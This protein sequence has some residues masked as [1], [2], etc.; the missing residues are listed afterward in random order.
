MGVALEKHFGR[1]EYG[2]RGNQDYPL[3]RRWHAA[4]ID[5]RGE[6]DGGA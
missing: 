2:D 3:A 5:P 1:G 4:S 6:P